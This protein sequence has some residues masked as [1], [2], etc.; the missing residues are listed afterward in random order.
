[1]CFMFGA[2]EEQVRRML[3]LTGAKHDEALTGAEET[4]VSAVTSPQ[5]WHSISVCVDPPP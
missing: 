5:A 3:G 2:S 4:P 1:M